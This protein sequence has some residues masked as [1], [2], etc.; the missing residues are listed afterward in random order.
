M[1]VDQTNRVKPE[2]AAG[3]HSG[4]VNARRRRAHDLQHP[5]ILAPFCLSEL[6]RTEVKL[7][8]L[9]KQAPSSALHEC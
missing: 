8:S 7:S 9:P 4:R 5:E 2:P 3:F 6:K 1:S